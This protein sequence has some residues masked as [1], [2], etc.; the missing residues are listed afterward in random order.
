MEPLRLRASRREHDWRRALVEGDDALL[1]ELTST[2]PP[3]AATAMLESFIDGIYS[4][5]EVLSGL[6]IEARP[7]IASLVTRARG[8]MDRVRRRVGWRQREL[9]LALLRHVRADGALSIVVGAGASIAAGGLSWPDMVDSLLQRAIEVGHEH[10]RMVPLET[11][12]GGRLTAK[13]RVVGVDRLDAAA[14]RRAEAVRAAIAAERASMHELTEG[15]EICVQLFGQLAFQHLYPMLYGSR[16]GRRPGPIHQAVAAIASAQ[17]VP[18]RRPGEFPGWEAIITYNFDDLMGEALDAAGVPRASWAMKAG[19]PKGDPNRFAREGGRDAAH[20]PI[21]HLHGY[22]PRR[23]FRITDVQFVLSTS[24]Y[25][26][27][28]DRRDGIIH[29]VYDRYLANPPHRALY[30]GCSFQD[31]AMNDMLRQAGERFPGRNHWA[32]LEWP[33][34]AEYRHATVAEIEAASA[35]YSAIG[36]RPVW[37]DRFDEI[38]GMIR[39]LA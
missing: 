30:V 11:G 27:M 35:P 39:G 15:A 38:P 23:P 21:Y 14:A 29:H 32:L 2:E 25:Q 22:S 34:D 4:G 8:S 26:A 3:G 7:D 16:R 20:T 1:A 28:Y 12:E 19:D 5:S 17:P 10:T 9:D 13:R 36:V 33:G 37:F 6:G 31:D 18:G 24:Q